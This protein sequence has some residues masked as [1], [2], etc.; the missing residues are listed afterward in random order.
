MNVDDREARLNDYLDGVLTPEEAATVEQELAR[1]ADY[2]ALETSLRRV[3]DEAAA[4]PK[5][6]TPQRDL[7]AGIEA[8]LERR[9]PERPKG[10]GRY[11]YAL[12]AASFAAVFFA[13]ILF[14]QFQWGTPPQD[15][16]VTLVEPGKTDGSELAL[17]EAEYGQA[18]ALLVQALDDSRDQLS[19]E[20]VAVVDENLA[21]IGT[22]IAEIKAALKQDPANQQLIR[23]LVAAYDQEVDLLQ[24]ATQLPAQL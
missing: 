13:G 17:V 2:R 20:T 19:P 7:W 5:T 16:T 12:L 11:R 23:S 9:E 24:Q 18:R 4:L 1:D 8:R 14:A 10:S 21:I 22:A 6:V 3:M 15:T